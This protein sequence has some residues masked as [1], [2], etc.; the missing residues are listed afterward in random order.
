LAKGKPARPTPTFKTAQLTA[1]EK[2]VCEKAVRPYG[3]LDYLYRLRIKA[4]Y[5]DAEM[6]TE[7][8]EDESSSVLV[9]MSMVRIATAMMIAHETRIAQ[10]LGRD[11]ILDQARTWVTKNAASDTIGIGLRLPIL[12]HVL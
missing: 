2:A 1:D 10:L 4:N 3:L 11:V 6:F 5:Q 12:E 9:A 7:G 8:P